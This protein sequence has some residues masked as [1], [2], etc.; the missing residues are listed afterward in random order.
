MSAFNYNIL[1]TGDCKNIGN[2]AYEISFFGGIAPYTVS[3]IDPV[4]GTLTVGEN[5]PILKTN[6]FAGT[7]ILT[8]NDSTLPVNQE[9]NINIPISSGICTSI[10]GV[11]NTTCGQNNGSVTGT[12][13]T[14]Y[15]SIDYF[16]YS[17]D[18]SFVNSATTNQ[19]DIVFGGLAEGSYYMTVLDLGGCTAKTQ[20]FI[21]QNST[22]TNFG[23][24]SVPNS[25]CGGSPIGKLIVTGLT[26][27]GPFTYLWSDGQT[28]TTATGLTEGFYSIE[29]TDG[30]GCITTQTGEVVNVDPIGLGG[31]TVVN[32]NCF[33]SDGQIT[34]T[35]TG[36]SQPY[37]Y[38]ASSGQVLVTYSQSFTITGL[39]AGNYEFLVTDAGFCTLNVGTN[40]QTPNGMSSVSVV[41][42]NSLCSNSDGEITVTVVG[43]QAPYTYT[44]VGENGNQ[45]IFNGSQQIQRFQNLSAGTYSV[46]VADSE[47]CIYSQE[48]IIL[49]SDKFTISTQTTGTT[50]NQNNGSIYI[51]TSSGFTLPLDYSVD[52]LQN[53]IDT[54]LT[55]VT[56]N[57]LTFGNHEVTVTDATGC[58]QKQTVF[59]PKGPNLDFSLYS[60]GCGVGNTGQITAFITS[61]TPPFQFNW[62]NNV[63]SNPQQINVENLTGGTYNLTI[64]DSNG[65]SLTRST[66]ITCN[67]NYTSYQCYVMAE[68]NFVVDSPTKQGLLQML[69]EGYFDLINN[70]NDCQLNSAEF[71]AKVEV[72]PI[73]LSATEP[74]YTAT[75]LNM[76]PGDNLWYDTVQELLLRIPG[77]SGVEID[78][79]NN[80]IK[81]STNPNDNS[82]NGQ[83]IIVELVINYDITCL[84]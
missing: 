60:V 75:T 7:N 74:F 10:L 46:F 22:Q 16:V 48:V 34:L 25:S 27:Q 30:F 18:G 79:I 3:F 32:P 59:L 45:T 37:Y 4:Y 71:V 53:I 84:N 24:Y 61:G 58:S 8:V 70:E 36:G 17:G 50:C 13:N 67:K 5:V 21:I 44:L 76:I 80:Q 19:T 51:E 69:N 52:G 81:I 15:S 56:F 9:F 29:V 41:G 49:T 2:G 38:S 42:T 82:L 28:G 72:N 47:T 64:V 6:L 66:T 78:A 12:S 65:C 33:Q 26:G 68:E 11:Q 62:S 83:E 23:L 77:V 35:I 40:L 55:A 63:P 54:N 57:N 73:G 14:V 39:S 43:G 1:V 31:F 20:D